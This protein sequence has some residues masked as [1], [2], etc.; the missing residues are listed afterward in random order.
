[1]IKK[2]YP[3]IFLL[4]SIFSYILFNPVN[5]NERTYL[6]TE[7]QNLPDNIRIH[8]DWTS[9]YDSPEG[10]IGISTLL[11]GPPYTIWLFL[12]SNDGQNKPTFELQVKD[13]ASGQ[14]T[15][16]ESRLIESKIGLKLNQTVKFEGIDLPKNSDIFVTFIGNDGGSNTL[17]FS[18]KLKLQKRSS[19]ISKTLRR[20]ASI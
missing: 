13:P 4:V 15:T 7:V 10:I 14:V 12:D 9:K 8:I 6:V 11:V 1:M 18:A 16:I 5:L 3:I 19:I 20:I 17:S 2:R